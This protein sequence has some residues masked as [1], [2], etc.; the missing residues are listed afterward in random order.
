MK[1]WIRYA[2]AAGVLVA[3]A[4]AAPLTA[5][6]SPASAI[7]VSSCGVA[8]S[9]S[10]RLVSATSP[11][12][13]CQ[14]VA[15][16]GTSASFSLGAHFHWSIPRSS[17]SSVKVTAKG[18]ARTAGGLT[19][20]FTAVH[21]GTAMITA[22]GVMVCPTGEACPDLAMLWRL[23]VTVVAST[24]HAA[25]TVTRADA[26]QSYTLVPGQ[27]VVVSLGSS[28][29]Y[30][31]SEPRSSDAAVLEM[32]SGTAGQATL[33][34]EAT[35]TATVTVIGDPS[36]APKCLVMSTIVLFHFTVTS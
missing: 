5:P 11:T 17:S 20:V 36:C 33:F 28:T 10:W 15:T 35:G 12:S 13:P 2:S 29:A 6:E 7:V 18:R 32:V 24:S 19:G 1:R 22:T 3:A 9:T 27:E 23:H 8:T 26:G 25:V 30:T 34:A 16:V 21:A 14:V 4:S 31:W